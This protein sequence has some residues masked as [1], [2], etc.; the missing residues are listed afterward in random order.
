MSAELR[1]NKYR[2]VAYHSAFNI[3]HS[4]PSGQVM[5]FLIMVL[6]ILAFIV[7]WNFDLHKILHIKS[8]TQNA[9]DAAAL[10]AARWQ[11]ITLNLIGDLNIM[12]ALALGSGATETASSITNIQ[13]RLC[14]VGPM[15]AL[16]AAQQAAKNNGIYPNGG[17][18][19]R[20]LEHARMVRYDYPSM[21]GP[22]G[23]ML[24]PEP[25]PDCWEEYADMLELIANDGVAAGPDNARYYG[26][27]TGGHYLLM[28]DFYE[29]IAGRNWCWFYHNAPTLLEDYEN[30][31]PCWWP[32][33]PEIPH[34]EPVNSEIFGL[35][36]SKI[37]TTLSSLVDFDTV[38]SAAA[39]RKF[40][41]PLTSNAMEIAA[42]WY[43]YDGNSWSSW[44]AM[45]TSGEDPFPLT[46]P[47]KP[48]YDYIGADSA[49]RIEATIDRLT[50][51]PGGSSVS[52]TITWSA[53]AKP[54]GY[55]NE[56]DRPNMYGLVMPAFHEVRLVPV[57][58][59]SAPSGGGYNLQWREHIE[60]H[61]PEYMVNGPRQSSCWYCQQ[62]LTW[63]DEDF[64]KAGVDWLE[65]NSYQC[66]ATDGGGGRHGGGTHRGH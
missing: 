57:D 40:D 56:Q 20:L 29:A 24:F 35:G 65:V 63:E 1:K 3:Q 60:E 50:P 61:L 11:G 41:T 52:N 6:V 58:A 32:A 66:I 30:F 2:F 8:I 28:I 46:G 18:T 53:A 5:I 39:E 43:C 54:F 17:F 9:G 7:L 22:D 21:T 45:S 64:R 14:Y 12:Q 19:Q 15:I 42:T 49:I 55:L 48:Q 62:L 34:M 10:V 26:D 23:E 33:L 31:F 13:A 36:L 51:G 38:S 59:S 37:T 16:M 47:V 27:Y 4:A 44:G 25:Y